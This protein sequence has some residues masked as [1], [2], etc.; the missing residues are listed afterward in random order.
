MG[1]CGVMSFKQRRRKAHL[2]QTQKSYLAASVHIHTTTPPAVARDAI[3]PHEPPLWAACLTAAPS[4]DP[5][6]KRMPDQD[7][8]IGQVAYR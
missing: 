5:S 7:T 8:N 3:L 1:C 6:T 4:M 2:I